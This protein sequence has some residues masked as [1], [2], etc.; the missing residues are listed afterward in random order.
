MNKKYKLKKWY[1]SLPSGLNEGDA[2]TYAT[3]WKGYTNSSLSR[4]GDMLECQE[5]ENNPEFWEPI[6]ER[7][8]KIL[9]LCFRN[10]PPYNIISLSQESTRARVKNGHKIHSVERLSDGEIFTV[11]DKMI[12][13]G[14]SVE[15]T[16][17]SFIINDDGESISVHGKHEHGSCCYS[18]STIHHQK[19]LFTTED[20]V[21]IYKGGTYWIAFP[22]TKNI[23]KEV[24]AISGCGK[25]QDVFYY[26]T[27]EKAQEWLEDN[28]PKYSKDDLRRMLDL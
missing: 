7:D 11:G 14:C 23:Q 26:S 16:I 18:F 2:I 6:V 15:R 20:G 27:E 12:D 1:P 22:R 24:G 21:D 8:Y 9:K 3:K 28:K 10:N 19:P 13:R 4:G 17:T 5:V 25:R